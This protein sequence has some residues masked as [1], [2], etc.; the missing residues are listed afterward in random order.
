MLVVFKL[1]RLH[2]K[3]VNFNTYMPFLHW[4]KY[5]PASK[6]IPLSHIKPFYPYAI[7]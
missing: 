7:L 4:K 3:T 1:Y 2:S 6:N 5:I